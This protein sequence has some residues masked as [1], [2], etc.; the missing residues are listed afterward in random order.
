M[1]FP[2]VSVR[3]LSV[4]VRFP[5]FRQRHFIGARRNVR[6]FIVDARSEVSVMPGWRLTRLAGGSPV[7]YIFIIFDAQSIRNE[8]HRVFGKT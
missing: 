3:F 7:F 5:G 1:R 6:D 2:L 4:S 8:K